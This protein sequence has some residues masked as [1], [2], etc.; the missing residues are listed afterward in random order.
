[1]ILRFL[2]GDDVFISYSRAD[3]ATYAAGL[4]D[5][6]A[7]RGF[8][9]RLDQW[10]TEA[11]AKMPKSLKR[12]LRRSVALV[13]VG[14]AGAA[15]SEHVAEEVRAIKRKRRRVV[16]VLFE[17]V[18]LKDGLTPSGETL[19]RVSTP[20]PDGPSPDAQEALWAE[21]IKG[22]PMS[23]EKSEALSK[24]EPSKEVLTRI[25]K[26]C[27]F[28]KKDRRLRLASAVV[29]VLLISLVAA[30]V[31]AGNIALDKVEEARL[32]TAEAETAE[33]RAREQQE[34]ARQKTLEADA[35]TRRATEAGKKATAAEA[36]AGEK[37][38]LAEEQQKRA[39]AASKKAAEQ[40]RLAEA[41]GAEA[42]RQQRIALAR[43]AA[44]RADVLRVQA[45]QNHDGWAEMLQQST[46]LSIEAVRRLGELS[47]SSADS[48][49]PLREA[50]SLL[51]RHVRNIRHEHEIQHALLTPDGRHVLAW[52]D[53]DVLRMY[54]AEGRRQVSENIKLESDADFALDDHRTLLAAY[55]WQDKRLTLR[56][57]PR[58]NLLWENRDIDEID[59]L[60][61]SPDGRRLAAAVET[62]TSGSLSGPVHSVVVWDTGSGRRIMEVKAAGWVRGV[63]LS[64]FN[65]MLALS[66]DSPA[67]AG[68]EC[69]NTGENQV[70]I[71]RINDPPT[72]VRCTRS[73]QSLVALVFSPDGRLL[74][75]GSD[76]GASIWSIGSGAE[77]TPI[78]DPAYSGE[79]A[80]DITRLSFSPDGRTIGT[81]SK[82]RAFQTWDVLTG[83][84]HWEEVVPESEDIGE[85]ILL[86]NGA[87]ARVVDVRT[88]RDVAR[89]IQE[90]DLKGVDYAPAANRLLVYGK[91]RVW[92]YDTSTPLEVARA[93]VDAEEDFSV[94]TPDRRYVALA[95]G[96][97]VVLWGTAAA[98]EV[99][100]LAHGGEV[101]KAVFSS[102]GSRLVTAA[103]DGGVH[104]WEAPTGRELWRISGVPYEGED[105]DGDED[106]YIQELGFSPRG[107]FLFMAT[108]APDCAT[109]VW[110][111][112]SRREVVCARERFDYSLPAVTFTQDEKHV[113]LYEKSRAR[114]LDTATGDEVASPPFG[115]GAG[116]VVLSPDNRLMAQFVGKEVRASEIVGGGKVYDGAFGGKVSDYSF[117]PD[118]KFL[119][120]IGGEGRDAARIFEAASG[121]PVAPLPLGSEVTQFEFSPGGKHLVTYGRVGEQA[122]GDVRV[123]ELASGRQLGRHTSEAGIYQVIF[124]PGGRLA[125]TIGADRVA[126]VLDLVAGRTVAELAHGGRVTDLVFSADGKN[127]ATA[128][129]DSHARVW[130]IAGRRELVRLPHGDAVTMV[131]FGH[132]GQ[133]L[134]T[135]SLDGTTR[136]WVLSERELISRA[137]LRLTRNLSR[138]EWLGF[139]P[140]DARLETTCRKL[141]PD[142][143]RARALPPSS[144]GRTAPPD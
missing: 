89:F 14:T 110:E 123:W 24:G 129:Y 91:D 38:R 50:L 58:G 36:L 107:N 76:R 5:E 69:D 121:R 131:A 128:S 23:C 135:L 42:A 108:L 10:G 18:I 66:V 33:R 136:V 21:E 43:Q 85:Y 45:L 139:F 46:L 70:Q 83:K 113:L 143:M 63:A 92:L 140:G 86:R 127:L 7:K 100:R 1:M 125:A 31:F 41:A 95:A 120:V 111:I 35:A 48:S 68:V 55:R 20:G 22:L 64:P 90:G 29:A 78:D 49:Q 94:H 54:E 60:T 75:A 30:S 59:L 104:V 71:W 96:S 134:A 126:R 142:D 117:S 74:A 62:G 88:G 138:S 9:C 25:E 6:L 93:S 101:Y 97:T 19:V 52:G 17:G 132:G 99:A 65:D 2:F 26:T 53:D 57:L 3:G 37:T 15:R 112:G 122:Q 27:N 141:Q 137:C 82:D 106:F 39:E 67:E 144:D 114:V 13:L 133:R 79:D 44:T 77:F 32:K 130:D 105:K 118:G 8:S 81:M 11:G 103:K 80:D 12:A 34:V 102:D 16:P 119:V 73:E 40:T 4:A 124:G 51:P 28:W 98:R 56:R 47:L 115:E 84:K 109:R 87:G 116:K 61:F 72:L